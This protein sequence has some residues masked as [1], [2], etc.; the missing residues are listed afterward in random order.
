MDVQHLKTLFSSFQASRLCA[1]L[2]SCENLNRVFEKGVGGLHQA[3]TEV[4]APGS[5]PFM[6]M[7]VKNATF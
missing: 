6:F 2:A 3:L 1:G 5:T 7:K 4:K